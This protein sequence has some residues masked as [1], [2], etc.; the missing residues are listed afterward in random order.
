MLTERKTMLDAS[1]SGNAQI[2]NGGRVLESVAVTLL[3][4]MFWMMG[5]VL[6]SGAG[7]VAALYATNP[8]VS[9]VWGRAR[10]RSGCRRKSA[11]PR[12]SWSGCSNCKF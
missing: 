6:V 5:V 7:L 10:T 11:S 4:V 9:V 1:A 12:W 8:G 3:T 2:W